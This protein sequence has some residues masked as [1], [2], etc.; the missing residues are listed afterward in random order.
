MMF[1]K[2]QEKSLQN[3]NNF[4]Y[5]SIRVEVNNHSKSISNSNPIFTIRSLKNNKKFKTNQSTERTF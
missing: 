1:N 2:P 5:H 3:Y 4:S